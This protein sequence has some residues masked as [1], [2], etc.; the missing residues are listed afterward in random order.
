MPFLDDLFILGNSRVMN[1][2][3]DQDAQGGTLSSHLSIFSEGTEDSPCRSA[4][5]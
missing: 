1:L 5:A 2:D 4:Q 3:L